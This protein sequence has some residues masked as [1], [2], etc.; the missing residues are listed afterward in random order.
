MVGCAGAARRSGLPREAS[1]QADR[2]EMALRLRARFPTVKYWYH[3]DEKVG[4]FCLEYGL[5]LDPHALP[6]PAR[7]PDLDAIRVLASSY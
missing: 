7:D 1:M 5:G 4:R 2:H 3:C 6:S